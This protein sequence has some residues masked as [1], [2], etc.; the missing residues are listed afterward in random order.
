VLPVGGSSPLGVLG[1]VEAALELAEQVAVGDLPAPAE[2]VVAAGSGGTAAGLAVGLGLAGLDARVTGVVVT[3][4]LVSERSAARL[5]RRTAALLRKRGAG[6][7][8]GTPAE[9]RILEGY[10]GAGYGHPTPEGKLATE[11]ARRDGLAL[12]PVY[13]A[14]AVAGLLGEARAGRLGAGPVLYLHTD[15]P[16]PAAEPGYSAA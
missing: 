5:V 3:D 8:M 15:G 11:L 7:D 1:Y 16:R 4:G 12:D 2:V 6:P 9:L 14:K 10:R 13:T